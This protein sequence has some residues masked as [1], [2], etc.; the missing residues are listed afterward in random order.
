MENGRVLKCQNKLRSMTKFTA[1]SIYQ[2][3][4]ESENLREIFA[5]FLN[6]GC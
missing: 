3:G 6:V 1:I 2:V 5:L 4:D